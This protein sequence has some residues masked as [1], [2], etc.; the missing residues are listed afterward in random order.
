MT[1]GGMSPA[2]SSAERGTLHSTASFTL[3]GT[4][5]LPFPF[6]PCKATQNLIKLFVTGNLHCRVSVRACIVCV[7]VPTS[8]GASQWPIC[9]HEYTDTVNVFQRR[10]GRIFRRKFHY[11]V[12]L[13]PNV[14]FSASYRTYLSPQI[15]LFVS[16]FPN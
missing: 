16:L 6:S 1:D 8:C 4:T 15:A 13:C 14:D 10:T 9:E 12:S 2:L 11:C 3:L 5:Q 7:C